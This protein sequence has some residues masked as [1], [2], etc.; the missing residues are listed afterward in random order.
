[1]MM[2]PQDD[3]ELQNNSRTS[4]ASSDLSKI[5]NRWHAK[6]TREKKK[7]YMEVM[8]D[9][10]QFLEMEVRSSHPTIR[11]AL[12]YHFSVSL[13]SPFSFFAFSVSFYLLLFSRQ[14]QALT[15]NFVEN[16]TA[17]IL[18][19]LGKHPSL[20]LF[21][22]FYQMVIIL[23]QPTTSPSKHRISLFFS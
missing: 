11:H 1:M 2:S 14:G 6:K 3:F 4:S 13:T 12:K 22:L 19:H 20:S 8:K 21:S 18:L 5:K 10:L 9:R 7:I 17:N 15:K 23:I 16:K